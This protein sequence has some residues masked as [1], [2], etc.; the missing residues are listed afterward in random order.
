VARRVRAPGVT[1]QNT[2]TRGGFRS[3]FVMGEIPRSLEHQPARVV[4][5]GHSLH[6]RPAR[7]VARRID[8]DDVAFEV[9][10]SRLCVVHLTWTGTGGARWPRFEL[11]ERLPEED[12]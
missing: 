12:D 11:V 10:R 4:A 6:G 7:A 8:D 1:D 2:A 3:F 9:E 5:E